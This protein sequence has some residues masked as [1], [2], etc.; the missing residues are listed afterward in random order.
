MTSAMRRLG[1]EISKLGLRRRNRSTS[2]SDSD[3]FSSTDE[4]PA[5]GGL[6]DQPENAFSADASF[7]NRSASSSVESTD[8]LRQRRHSRNESDEDVECKERRSSIKAA[9]RPV[10]SRK[11]RS[12]LAKYSRPNF[13]HK[14]KQGPL[15]RNGSKNSIKDGNFD[16]ITAAKNGKGK[17]TK[18][19]SFPY[20]VAGISEAVGHVDKTKKPK[21]SRMKRSKSFSG[22][23]GWRQGTR[24]GRKDSA[25]NISCHQKPLRRTNSFS[26]KGNK[27]NLNVENSIAKKLQNQALM[28]P[29][30]NPT[31]RNVS[32]NIYITS[33]PSS[34][35]GEHTQN[36]RARMSYRSFMALEGFRYEEG[37]IETDLCS[38]EL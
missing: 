4:L 23:L 14:L 1:Q 25:G 17:E 29:D 8:P 22:L 19:S 5:K 26:G 21:R 16:W 13:D 12:D 36:G 32:P 33:F 3:V 28:T 2:E 10:L 30:T 38:T 35:A 7:E 37:M 15:E 9:L 6:E 24:Q 20:R 11:S 31:N 27:S 34:N 18:V